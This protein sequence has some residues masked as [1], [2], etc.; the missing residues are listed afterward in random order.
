M[1]NGLQIDV[2][3]AEL[4]T[5]LLGRLKFHQDKVSFYEKQ[6]SSM[7]SVDAALTEEARRMGKTSTAGP[8]ESLEQAIKKHS[9]QTIYYKFMADHVVASETYRLAEND[10]VR[11][12]VQAER[13]Y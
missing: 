3:A 4:K 9:D 7:R 12:G 13:Y 10:L 2:T 8:I 5:L 6:L 1:I 11:L